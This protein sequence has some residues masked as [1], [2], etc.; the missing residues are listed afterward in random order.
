MM[1]SWVGDFSGATI[2]VIPIQGVALLIL[3]DAIAKYY[4]NCSQVTVIET[5]DF[6]LRLH[7]FDGIP[8]YHI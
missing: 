1:S 2:G 8:L 7:Q 5:P 3:I 6:L 4:V